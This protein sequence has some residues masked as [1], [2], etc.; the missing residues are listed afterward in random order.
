MDLNDVSDETD[1]ID[2]IEMVD[3]KTA[4]RLRNL[5]NPFNFSL[6]YRHYKAYSVMWPFIAV[7]G[8]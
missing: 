8:T 7:A 4:D 1:Q 6:N 5:P 2:Y 3:Q